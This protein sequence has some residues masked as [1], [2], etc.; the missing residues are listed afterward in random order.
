MVFIID[1]IYHEKLELYRNA[2]I[3]GLEVA[4]VLE[5]CFLGVAFLGVLGDLEFEAF[6]SILLQRSRKCQHI[7]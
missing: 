6:F 3:P 5:D 7:R 1:M 4:A 2:Y